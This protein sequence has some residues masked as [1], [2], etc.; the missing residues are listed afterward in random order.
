M[1]SAIRCIAACIIVQYRYTT[2]SCNGNSMKSSP[3]YLCGRKFKWLV[4]IKLLVYTRKIKQLAKYFSK[5]SGSGAFEV[6][7]DSIR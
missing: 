4:E 3:I 5:L 6:N 1:R 7:L 2:S